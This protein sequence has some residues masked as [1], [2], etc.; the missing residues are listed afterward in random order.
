[1]VTHLN[2]SKENK[3]IDMDGIKVKSDVKA[4]NTGNYVIKPLQEAW[5]V[6]RLPLNPC[7]R[8][9]RGR[10]IFEGHKQRM[11]VSH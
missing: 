5:R 11:R 7:Q 8:S 6:P 9:C 1:M 4:V 10:E 3:Q 2:C